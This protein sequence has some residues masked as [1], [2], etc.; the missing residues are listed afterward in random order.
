MDERDR[1][2]LVAIA[3]WVNVPL[4]KLPAEMRFHTCVDTQAAW[5][6]VTDAIVAEVH[7]AITLT[8]AKEHNDE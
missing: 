4:D 1:L 3:A 8:E 7:R 5:K 2:A 6:R